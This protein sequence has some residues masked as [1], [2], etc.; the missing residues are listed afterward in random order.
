MKLW[1]V[2]GHPGG[3][4]SGPHEGQRRWLSALGA[5]DRG[6][7]GGVQGAESSGPELGSDS[8]PRSPLSPALAAHGSNKHL[9]EMFA[10]G[11]HVRLQV[12]KTD[13]APIYR[14]RGWLCSGRLS[15][16]RSLAASQLS[17]SPK[18]SDSGIRESER[19]RDRSQGSLS[20]PHPVF[21]PPP[22]REGSV[23]QVDAKWTGSSLCSKTLS[24]N[25][26]NAHGN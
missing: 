8:L 5:G 2:L 25:G 26:D 19:T 3:I 20:F 12:A 21:P 6:P 16:L 7:G 1:A 18:G 15:L 9:A 24:S 13:S 11:C 10:S 17:C 23:L 22:S 4:S 14:Y